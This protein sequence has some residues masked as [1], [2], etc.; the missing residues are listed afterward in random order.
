MIFYDIL[1]ST[2]YPRR[3]RILP[4]ALGILTRLRNWTIPYLTILYSSLP[5]SSFFT[6]L[7]TLSQLKHSR[8]HNQTTQDHLLY[9]TSLSHLSNIAALPSSESPHCKVQL[10]IRRPLRLLPWHKHFVLRHCNSPDSDC[11]SSTTRCYQTSALPQNSKE[12]S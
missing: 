1:Y 11:A 2:P 6:T 10:H 7:I 9:T 12:P 5:Y 8:T 4:E 3:T